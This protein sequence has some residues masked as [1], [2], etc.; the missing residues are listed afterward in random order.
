MKKTIL[1]KTLVDI[2][3]ILHFI[4][5]NRNNIYYTFWSCQYQS[6]QCEY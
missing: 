6:S 1:F 2:L 3:Y 5:A 4:G